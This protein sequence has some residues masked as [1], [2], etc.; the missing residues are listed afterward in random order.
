LLVV[1]AVSSNKDLN[2]VIAPLVPL[3]DAWYA[4]RNDSERSF[5]AEQVAER[6][7]AAGGRV[8]DLGTVREALSAARDAAAADDLILVTGSFY[9]VADARPLFVGT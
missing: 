4:A 1:L 8:A 2:G 3:A 9:T 6:I 7:A 5:P